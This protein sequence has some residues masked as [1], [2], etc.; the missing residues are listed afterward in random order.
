MVKII[1]GKEFEAVDSA[2]VDN[3]SIFLDSSDN[4]LKMKNNS[5]EVTKI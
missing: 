2:N 1:S 3:N 5:G 4:I